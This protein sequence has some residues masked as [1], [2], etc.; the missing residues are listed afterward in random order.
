MARFSRSSYLIDVL[1]LIGLALI[2]VAVFLAWGL[3]ATLA[4]AGTALIVV[5]AVLALTPGNERN[6]GGQA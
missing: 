3:A 6:D 2:G 4:Y 5:A 1:S